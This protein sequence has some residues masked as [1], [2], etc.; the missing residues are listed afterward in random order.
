VP[1]SSKLAMR[2]SNNRFTMELLF[3]VDWEVQP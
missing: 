1:A 3:G 2:N